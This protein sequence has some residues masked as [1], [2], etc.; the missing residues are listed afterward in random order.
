MSTRWEL[1][2]GNTSVFAVRMGFHE[3]DSAIA[4]AADVEASWGALEIWVNGINLCAHVEAGETLDAVHWYLLPLLEWLANSW[5]AFLHEERLPVRNAGVDAI[6]SLYRT[7]FPPPG[8]APDSAREHEDAWYSWRE[9][10]ALH[11]ARDGGL[12]PEVFVRRLGDRIEVSW[13]DQTPTGAPEDYAFLI[14]QGRALLD[15]EDVARP[16]FLVL[17]DAVAQLRGW[18]PDSPRLAALARATSELNKPAKQRPSRLDWLFDIQVEGSAAPDSWEAVKRLFAGTSA[19][20][21]KATLIPTGSGLVLRGSSH[22]VLLFGSVSPTVSAGDARQLA[23]LLVNLFDERGDSSEL[24]RLVDAVASS[25]GDGLPWEQGYDLAEEAHHAIDEDVPGGVKIETILSALGV[26]VEPVALTDARIRGVAVAG[27]QHRAAICPNDS[28]PLNK[29]PEGLRFT[30]AHELCHLLIDRQAGRKLAVAS[31]PWAPVD[32]EKRADA[33][34]AAFLM[35]PDRVRTKIERLTGPVHSS[36][37][38][39]TLAAAFGTSVSATVE[40][41]H[42][43]GWLDEFERDELRGVG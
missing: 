38:V 40:H 26:R 30:L 28:H 11:A 29:S 22:A 16:L 25:G 24:S 21:R 5:N 27:S 2:A 7:R 3:D 18:V 12:F 23:R 9:R 10:H 42:N 39:R 8:L 15:P 34:A 20:V 14:P 35:P 33:F 43:L 32:V 37:A 36:E 4:L 1:L 13:S 17:R 19:A 6:E 31:G 41:L